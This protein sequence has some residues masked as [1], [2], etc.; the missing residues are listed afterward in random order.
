MK[1]ILTAF[2]ALVLVTGCNLK[3]DTDT[4]RAR[5]VYFGY[6]Q[7][8]LSDAAMLE[9]NQQAHDMMHASLK[10]SFILEGHTDSRGSKSYNMALGAKRANSVKE[11]LV[12][13][14][15]HP[16]RLETISYGEERPAVSGSGE[17]V[18]CKNRRVVTVA[19]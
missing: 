17:A 14:G 12:T 3:C 16:D 8:T 1:K 10:Q 6:N 18:W 19:K 4:G 5:V 7:Y 13:K 9:L 2:C 11:Y 15:I